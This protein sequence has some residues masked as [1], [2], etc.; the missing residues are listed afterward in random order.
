[1]DTFANLTCH[2]VIQEVLLTGCSA[3]GLSTYLHADYIGTL[4]PP[5][6]QKYRAMP[7]SGFFLLQNNVQ[8]SPVYPNEMQTVFN[9][10]NCSGTAEILTTSYLSLV[11]PMFNLIWLEL[12]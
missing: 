10:Q 12:M 7:G 4:M 2:S 1:M 3:G 8:N 6:V 11:Y 5:T 9:M